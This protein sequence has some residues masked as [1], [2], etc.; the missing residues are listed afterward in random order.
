MPNAKC[1]VV[2]DTDL[3]KKNSMM[4]KT[5]SHLKHVDLN[6]NCVFKSICHKYNN[7]H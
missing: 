7:V 3:P 4:F 5:P 1:F 6:V 2:I